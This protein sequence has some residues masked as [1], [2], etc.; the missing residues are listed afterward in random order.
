MRGLALIFALVLAFTLGVRLARLRSGG[1][2][3]GARLGIL[4]KARIV[5]ANFGGPGEMAQ[6]GGRSL[7][8]RGQLGHI[9]K[10]VADRAGLVGRHGLARDAL[11]LARF[12]QD[13]QCER[14]GAP[15]GLV[16]PL[17]QRGQRRLHP[18]P[19]ARNRQAQ[20][21]APRRLITWRE[22]Q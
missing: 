6:V 4:G 18:A 17:Q 21:Q 15:R 9:P 14:A 2:Q 13:R 22:R 5:L 8:R 10:I 12:T 11:G 20:R 3:H 7:L 19:I 1:G 16:L